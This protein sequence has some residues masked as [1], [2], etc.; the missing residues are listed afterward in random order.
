MENVKISGDF[1]RPIFFKHPMVSKT[2]IK[3]LDEYNLP[4]EVVM[5]FNISTI[6]KTLTKG[7]HWELPGHILMK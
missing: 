2:W 5:A 7:L 3:M 4:P 1:V 6:T